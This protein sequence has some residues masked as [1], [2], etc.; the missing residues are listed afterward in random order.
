MKEE[1]TRLYYESAKFE[2]KVEKLY[3][4]RM[5][6]AGKYSHVQK[7]EV[8]DFIAKVKDIRSNLLISDDREAETKRQVDSAG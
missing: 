4:F 3:N 8:R 1:L 2:I 5:K 6:F 7:V